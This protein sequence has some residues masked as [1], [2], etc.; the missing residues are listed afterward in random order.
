MKLKYVGGIKR[1]GSYPKVKI[2]DQF[3]EIVDGLIDIADNGEAERLVLTGNFSKSGKKAPPADN[4]DAPAPGLGDHEENADREASANKLDEVV[5][6]DNAEP[7]ESAVATEDAAKSE[8][9]DK[10]EKDA[11]VEGSEGH[12]A[13][14]AEARELGIKATRN[15][16]VPKLQEAIAEAKAGK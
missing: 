13:L 3:V 9:S 12:D 15:W 8:G 4:P 10:A 16:G 1:D 5:I 2:G 11:P 7:Q 6:A 14:I